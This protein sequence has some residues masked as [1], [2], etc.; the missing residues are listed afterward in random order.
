[1]NAKDIVRPYKLSEE[2]IRR[3]TVYYG[4]A[5]GGFQREFERGT[6]PM[7]TS[8]LAGINVLL[9]QRRPVEHHVHGRGLA[10]RRAH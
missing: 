1:M 6:F 2:E 10:S 9:Q 5:T 8:A 3:T 4:I 7:I